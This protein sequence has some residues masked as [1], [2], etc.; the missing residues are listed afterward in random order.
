MND[1]YS[2]L[3]INKIIDLIKKNL[4]T[5]PG[6]DLLSTIKVFPTKEILIKEFE[7]F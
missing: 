1:V 3:E 2:I 4:K 5:K 6:N 7:K